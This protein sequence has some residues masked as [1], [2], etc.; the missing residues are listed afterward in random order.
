[1]CAPRRAA[2]CACAAMVARLPSK[3]PTVTLIWAMATLAVIV[4]RLF[5]GVDFYD[6]DFRNAD[7]CNGLQPELSHARSFFSCRYRRA[8]LGRPAG[9]PGRRQSLPQ[10]RLSRRLA[11]LGQRQRQ[12]RMAAAIPEP[13]ARR[14]S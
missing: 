14:G 4:K 13:V 2:S 11:R 10:A 1:M 8:R 6:I 3:S 9:F 7:F 12:D 5:I